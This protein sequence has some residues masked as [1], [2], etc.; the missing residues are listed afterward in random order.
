MPN[1]MILSPGDRAAK[2]LAGALLLATA[3]AAGA[4]IAHADDGQGNWGGGNWQGNWGGGN[5][6]GNWQGNWHG[7]LVPNWGHIPDAG[8]IVPNWHGRH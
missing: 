7:D 2:A 8:D 4:G 6:Q 3:L 1:K 5:W